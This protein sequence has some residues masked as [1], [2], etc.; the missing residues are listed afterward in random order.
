MDYNCF[1]VC[2][3][4]LFLWFTGSR[5][6]LVLPDLF[7]LIPI[8]ALKK[9]LYFLAF[10]KKKKSLSLVLCRIFN[11]NVTSWNATRPWSGYRPIG[12]TILIA[13]SGKIISNRPIWQNGSNRPIWQNG[14]N[15]PMWQNEYES[16]YLTPMT[17]SYAMQCIL[18]LHSCSFIFSSHIAY[19]FP[20]IITHR[21]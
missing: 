21:N 14:F 2:I 1:C 19:Q 17:L 4:V 5:T 18:S 3:N 10:V 6:C 20:K 7:Y 15:R 13:P 11:A 16:P 12:I 9:K 8:L